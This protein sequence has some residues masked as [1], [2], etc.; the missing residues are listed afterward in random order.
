MIPESAEVVSVNLSHNGLLLGYHMATF[1]N[2]PPTE[3]RVSTMTLNRV[4]NLTNNTM[5]ERFLVVYPSLDN[6]LI[7]FHRP[8]RSQG[9]DVVLRI[10]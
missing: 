4:A 8:N 2:E 7:W 9:L 5:F 1:G 6:D 3:I 10:N